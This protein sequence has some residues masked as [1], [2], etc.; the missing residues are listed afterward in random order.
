LTVAALLRLWQIDQIP[1][2]FHLDESFEGLEAWRILTEPSYR[3]IFLTGNFGVPP[4][5]AYA[6]AL[7]FAVVQWMG[8]EAGPTAMRV[9]AALFG[10]LGVWVLFALGQEMR[11]RSPALISPGLPWLAAASLATMRWHIHFSRMGIEPV[12]VPMFWA[13]AMWLLLRAW[14]TGAWWAFAALGAALAL[15][16]YAYQGAW[17]IPPVVALAGVHLLWADRGD[18]LA[19]TRRWSGLAVAAVIATAG[20]IPLVLFFIAEPDL[21]VLRPAQIA[22]IGQTES[23]ADSTFTAALWATA[24]MFG[25]FGSPGD[26]D[27]RRN[28]PGAPALNLWQAIGFYVG[29]LVALWHSRSFWFSRRVWHKDSVTFAMPIVALIGLLVPGMISEYAPH[30]HR[31]LGAAAPVAL[32]CGIGLDYIGHS[33]RRFAA[34]SVR[35]V[36][37]AVVA[38]LLIAGTVTAGRDYFVRWAS[39]PDLFYAFDVGLWELG[40]WVAARAGDNTVYVSPQGDNH[41][42]LA[43][44]WRKLPAGSPV[45][46]DGR[47]ILPLTAGEN[48]LPEQYAVIEHEDFRTRLLLPG[49]FPNM[50][51]DFVLHDPAGEIYAQVYTRPAHTAPQ[52]APKIPLEATVGD[53]ITLIGYDILPETIRPGASLYVQYHWQVSAPPATDWT[54]FTH[55]VDAGG[56]VVAGFDSPPGRGSLVTTRWRAGWRVL[57]EYELLLPAELPAG[58]YTLRMGLYD[59]AG[60]HLPAGETA[61]ELGV[62][63]LVQ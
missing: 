31:V 41:A 7:T 4:L 62:I 61:I 40:Q 11:H 57:D 42:T 12:M 17:F 36:G 3:P 6:N 46:Y 14:R 47:T 39:L 45:R 8:G 59:A 24:K 43:F 30:F 15:S 33:T 48:E 53:G 23:P 2:G 34:S 28:L 21:L 51:T 35:A 49:L 44:A 60:N 55:M 27:P 32:L 38:L 5:N 29:L 37:P 10:V 9:T 50:T 58:D 63:T 25:P 22:I 18:E 19:R 52:R 20:V 56:Q 54:V 1:P 26:L 13:L 16:I